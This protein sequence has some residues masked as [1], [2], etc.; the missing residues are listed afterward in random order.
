MMR[1][2]VVDILE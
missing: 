1:P 2:P